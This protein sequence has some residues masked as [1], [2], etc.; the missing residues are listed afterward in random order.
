VVVKVEVEVVLVVVVV[1]VLVDV[2][3]EVVD[4]VVVEVV[5]VEVDV[6]RVD[7]VVV[8]PV[9]VSVKVVVAQPRPSLMQHQFWRCTVHLLPV[10]AQS[11]GA[12]EVLS[13]LGHPR[14]F[15]AQHHTFLA[16]VQFFSNWSRPTMQSNGRS[17]SGQPLF[18]VSQQ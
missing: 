18:S 2:V 9:S 8:V 6:V 11:Y 15:F 16:A 4:V 14:P 5:V 7:E 3:S 13:W 10:S 17:F 12:S 1:L